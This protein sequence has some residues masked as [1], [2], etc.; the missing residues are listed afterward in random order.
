MLGIIRSQV[1]R[2]KQVLHTWGVAS[3]KKLQ[4]TSLFSHK[5]ATNLQG[6]ARVLSGVYGSKISRRPLFALGTSSGIPT[7]AVS[8]L[9]VLRARIFHICYGADEPVHHPQPGLG[10]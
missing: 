6:A 9:K 3:G 8:E 5:E 4:P 1:L 2:H 7:P 10:T